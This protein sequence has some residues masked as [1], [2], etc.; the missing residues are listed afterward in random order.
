MKAKE[1]RLLEGRPYSVLLGMASTCTEAPA[2]SIHT[3]LA[4][5]PSYVCKTCYSAL[6]KYG[7]IKEQ[8][9]KIST[10]LSSELIT[11]ASTST[12]VS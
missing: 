7:A 12:T 2:T 8:I 3:R 9:R 4:A 11:R 5:A 6:M 1:R 10:F